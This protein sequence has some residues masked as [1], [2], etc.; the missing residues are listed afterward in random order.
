TYHYVLVVGTGPKALEMARAIEGAEG[1]GLRLVGFVSSQAGLQPPLEGLL[2]SYPVISPE[3]AGQFLR[4]HVVD[5][6]LISVDRDD[7]DR[8]EVLLLDC[9][10]E[11]VR[12]RLH[13]NFL[14]PST[15]RVTLEHLN[16]LPLITLSS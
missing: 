6:I 12:T 10:R 13:L 11:G 16:D 7:L 4:T 1:L 8:L 9:E 14:P 15:A 3:G 2:G 5:E